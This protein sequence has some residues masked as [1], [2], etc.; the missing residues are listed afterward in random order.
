MSALDRP[1]ITTMIFTLDEA[2]NLP[3]CLATLG[4]CDDVIVVDSFSSDDTEAI[5]RD[6]EARFV[7]RAFDGFGAQ[8]TWA[9]EHGGARHDWVLILDADE[10]VPAALAEE[11]RDAVRA[12]P[13]G[14]R[15]FRL[16]RRFHMWGRWLRY[17]SMY[18]TWVV[19]LV[20]RHHVRYVNRGH[21]ETQV[22][23][24]A[25]AALENDLDDENHKGLDHWLDRQRVYAKREAAYELS[26]E[27]ARSP[28]SGLLRGLLARDPLARRE[29]VKALGRRLPLR[30]L[31]FFL[32]AYLV[33]GG[34]RDGA[35]GFVYCVMKALYQAMIVLYRLE[36]RLVR[37]RAGQR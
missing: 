15:A 31:W 33:R 11:M 28:D 27:R 30:P 20:D 29:A 24:G 26:V 13:P 10:R 37:E 16:R 35:H 23:D 36:A 12:P 7:Q 22:V 9:L 25:V 34:W 6:A 19:R 5:A 3:G 21:A 17:S 18:P 4:W 2:V 32:Y 8:R 1:A 14:V